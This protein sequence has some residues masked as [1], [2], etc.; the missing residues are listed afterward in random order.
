MRNPQL[1]QLHDTTSR[2]KGRRC[3][4]VLSTSIRPSKACLHGYFDACRAT[5]PSLLEFYG[6][7]RYRGR[8]W[9]S[10]QKEQRSIHR[11]IAELRKHAD[12]RH[13]WCWRTARPCHFKS[14][15]AWGGAVHQYGTAPTLIKAFPGGRYAGTLHFEDM[16]ERAEVSCSVWISPRYLGLSAFRRPICRVE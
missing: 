12:Q 15:D 11:L 8:R 9:R 13:D 1:F 7:M 2:A 14:E 6:A 10:F 4:C 5:M 3:P 16:L